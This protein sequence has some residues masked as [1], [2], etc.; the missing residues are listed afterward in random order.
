[1]YP[2]SLLER[3]HTH[4]RM[5]HAECPKMK[6]L[7][8]SFFFASFLIRYTSAFLARRHF[9]LKH[10]TKVVNKVTALSTWSEYAEF[11]DGTNIETLRTCGE[12][13]GYKLNSPREWL[14]YQEKIGNYGAY[15]VLRCD[16]CSNSSNYYVWEEE[17]HWARLWNSMAS[18]SSMKL[19]EQSYDDSIC[20]S[21]ILLRNLINSYCSSLISMQNEH[22]NLRRTCMLTVLWYIEPLGCGVKAHLYTMG[23]SNIKDTV[24][25]KGI[26]T[27]LL[28][29]AVSNYPNRH[30][31]LPL[32]KLSSW[33]RL[34]RPLEQ[35]LKLQPG[36]EAF[37]TRMSD[38]SNIEILEGLT[39]NLF[40]IYPNG[41]LRTP[42]VGMLEGCAR[43]Q[44]LR[45]AKLLGYNVETAPITLDDIQT[46]EEVFCTSAVRL[47]VPV[48]VIL[49]ES[50]DVIWKSKARSG[51]W[52]KLYTNLH[53]KALISTYNIN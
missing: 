53:N 27:V 4:V 36:E 14:E 23:F 51:V 37:L 19:T 34:R 17:F 2:L 47:L 28:N 1:M 43:N 12:V 21:K 30:E 9:T 20:K 39:S 8:K 41:T 25:Q 35:R 42:A 7:S 11:D 33:C 3:S 16:I 29:P 22:L 26:V 6:R 52:L 31:H 13:D 38:E 15:T 49:T 45:V 10:V 44:V 40:V 5:V 48:K 18:I 24:Y 32:S 46:W 50:R